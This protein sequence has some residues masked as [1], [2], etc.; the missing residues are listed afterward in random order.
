NSGSTRKT[1]TFNTYDNL[2]DVV[3]VTRYYD[4]ANTTGLPD[5]VPNEGDF[6]IGRA[7]A[8]FDNLGRQYQSI[9]YNQPGTTAIVSNTWFDPNGNEIMSLP[10]GTQEFVKTVYDGLGE[11]T[12]VYD[13]Y[14]PSNS[15]VTYAA[16]GSL[17]D[18][19][20]LS[21]AET[22]YDPAGDATFVTS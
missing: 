9:A 13:G 19:V 21:Q 3:D 17:S 7:G 10:G 18:D 12:A 20:I 2:D 11:P 14:D 1:Y 16:A 15:T 8:A 22:V 6:V 5:N 4:M